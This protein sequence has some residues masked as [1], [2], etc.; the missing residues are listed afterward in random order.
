[1]REIEFRAY[2]DKDVIGEEKGLMHYPN[3]SSDFELVCNGDGG[4]SMV[5][6]HEDWVE[7]DKFSIMQY[8]GLKDKNGV[9][10]FEG[11]IV[12]HSKGYIWTVI[13]EIDE[14]R[15][16]LKC[17]EP[18]VRPLSKDRS[19]NIEVIGSIHENPE[20]IGESK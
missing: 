14:S 8:T 16:A 3:D 7:S 15:F 19:F 18:L 6:D 17:K 11:D 9:K 10:I 12:R 13:F 4:F 2:I 5:I 20:L 1:M